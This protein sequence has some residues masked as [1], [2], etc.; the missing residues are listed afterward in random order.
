MVICHLFTGFVT[1]HQRV[2]ATPPCSSSTARLACAPIAL[3]THPAHV[4]VHVWSR[5][6][7]RR[8][9]RFEAQCQC[10]SPTHFASQRMLVDEALDVAVPRVFPIRCRDRLP[11]TDKS[12]AQHLGTGHEGQQ[13]QRSGHRPRGTSLPIPIPLLQTQI[14]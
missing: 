6:L 9:G 4:H 13:R 2:Q 3:V 8:N 1:E 14:T 5:R 12:G 10:I 11:A 7:R